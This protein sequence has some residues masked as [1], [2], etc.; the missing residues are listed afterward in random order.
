M[1]DGWRAKLVSRRASAI[2]DYYTYFKA[3][4]PFVPTSADVDAIGRRQRSLLVA[5]MQASCHSSHRN[6]DPRLRKVELVPFGWVLACPNSLPQA[7]TAPDFRER[8]GEATWHDIV[9]EYESHLPRSSL[10]DETA[11]KALSLDR[12]PVARRAE[13]RR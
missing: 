6:V 2:R 4:P 9:D 3:H 10:M 7:L 5:E 12:V 1:L 11:F 13:D 8:V